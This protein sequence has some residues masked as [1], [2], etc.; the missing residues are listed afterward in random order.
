MFRRSFVLVALV[1]LVLPVLPAGAQEVP[2]LTLGSASSIHLVPPGE[3]AADGKKISLTVLV[4]DENGGL[5]KG[6]RFRGTSSSAGRID[7]DC[8]AVGPGLYSCGF[9]TPDRAVTAA[10]L[11]FRARLESGSEISASFPIDIVPRSRARI[12]FNANPAELILAQDPSSSIAFTVTDENGSPMDGL[13]LRATANVG[14]VQ[15]ISAAGGGTY[16]ALYVPPSQPFPQVAVISVWDANDPGNV[17]GFFRIP[18]VGNIN[19]PVDARAAGVTLIFTIGDRTFPPVVSDASGRA[20]VPIL[21]PPGVRFAQVELI[22]ATGSK[23]TQQIDL[24]PPPFSRIGIGGVPVFLPADGKKQARIRVFVVDAK[25]RPADGQDVVLSASQGQVGAARFVGNGLYEATY[26][27][28]WADAAGTATITASIKGHEAASTDSVEIGLEPAP[29][30]A[31]ALTADPSQITPNDKKSTLTAR[32]IDENGN[33][34]KGKNTVEFRTAEGPLKNPKSLGKST[35]TADV[36]VTWNVK[37]TVQAIASVRGNRQAV[38]QLVALPLNDWVMTGQKIPITVLSLDRYGNPVAD[39]AVNVAVKSGGGS[40]TGSVQTDARGIGTVVYSA[41]QLA[42]LG[43]VE[44]ISGDARY[45][46]PI[47]QSAEPMKK[48]EFPVS[49]GQRQG[50]TLAKWRKLRATVDLGTTPEPEPVAAAEPIS[51]GGGGLWGTGGDSTPTT[52]G[53]DSGSVGPAGAAAGIQVSTIPSSVA[54]TGG[55][56]NVL[57]KVVDAAG[58]LVPGTNVILITDTGTIAGKTDNGDGTFT[59]T[60]TIPPDTGKNSV[61]VTATRPEG[62]IAGFA[63]VQVGEAVAIAPGKTK[64]KTKKPKAKAVAPADGD[65]MQRR[66]G[67]AYVG[68]TPGAYLYDSTPC[69]GDTSP[70]DAPPDANLDDFDFLKVE[71]RGAEGEG[72]MPVPGSLQIGGEFFPGGDAIGGW[73]SIGPAVKYSRLSY[74]TNFA[75][76]SGDGDSHCATNFCDGMS[77]LTVDAQA[78]FALLRNQGPLDLIARVGYSFQDVVIFRRLYDPTTEEREPRFETVGLHSL[79]LGLGV[80]YTIVPMVQPHLDYN[81]TPAG[82]GTLGEASFAV[83]GVTNHNLAVGV[84]LFPFK[85]LLV[86]ATY[87]LTTRSLGLAYPNE[88]GENQ[89]GSIREQAHTFRLSAGW[90]F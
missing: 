42:G 4:T 54:E 78:R 39:V 38:R 40:V 29:P 31:I 74:T 81:I 8:P 53:S 79:R 16:S 44:F 7:Q 61:Q 12:A 84:S 88:V 27:A 50:R 43:A 57:V 65:R 70:C 18:L 67:Q 60:L 15:A 82:G 69:V 2:T 34:A 14:Q 25:G 3:I 19:Y 5:A 51:G 58:I 47:W 10:E 11:R 35:F 83:P 26:T 6:V 45:T 56:V 76:S 17:F 52:V 66:W 72:P 32:L 89:R 1:L 33:P 23:S 63:K 41:G 13:D 49:G 37:K 80:R 22:Q 24:Q 28:P 9:V 64:T 48:F 36:P 20:N 85:G 87:D 62:D 68:W 21:V 75:A 90:A 55:S 71:I 59:A 86:D 30:T 77:F 46:A 73:V